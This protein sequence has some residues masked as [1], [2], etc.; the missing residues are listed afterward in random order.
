[1]ISVTNNRTGTIGLPDHDIGIRGQ[2]PDSEL[3]KLYCEEALVG[4]IA[5][6]IGGSLQVGAGVERKIDRAAV[7]QC[8]V[9]A[10]LK[11]V[12]GGGT[13]VPRE[14]RET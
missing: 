13:T 9:K 14:S 4:N 3:T 6:G 7:I 10:G 11:A 8:K 5:L 2:I 12:I 1:M